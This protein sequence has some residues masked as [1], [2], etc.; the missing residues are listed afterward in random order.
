MTHFKLWDYKLHICVV[1]YFKMSHLSEYKV[2]VRLYMVMLCITSDCSI[3][4][5][6]KKKKQRQA[7]FPLS[8]ILAVRQEDQMFCQ[9]QN[10]G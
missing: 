2:M 6:K 10:A 9:M 5:K 4:E 7:F 3:R 1:G 8:A